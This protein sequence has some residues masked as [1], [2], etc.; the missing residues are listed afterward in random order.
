MDDIVLKEQSLKGY[1]RR[2]MKMTKR[3]ECEKFITEN[4]WSF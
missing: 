3:E 2:L 4:G 1:K